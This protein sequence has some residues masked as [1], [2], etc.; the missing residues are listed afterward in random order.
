MTSPDVPTGRSRV[1]WAVGAVFV[2]LIVLGVVF[3]SRFGDDPTLAAS[4][5]IGEPAPDVSFPFL[6]QPGTL[7]LGATRGDV[8][9]LNFW[10]SWCV[11]CRAEH[12]ILTGAARDYEAFGVTF[13]GALYQDRPSLGSAFLDEFGRGYTYV[14][15]EGSQAAI[16]FGVFGIPETYFIDR[17]GTVVGKISGEVT[18]GL[19]RATLD[20]IILGTALE[21]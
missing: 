20:A 15:D 8:V 18:D 5:L 3:A 1:I 12:P 11:P 17:S 6:E 14:Y 2:G 7:S 19:L 13:I 4:P 9:V 10:A 21:P 16:E